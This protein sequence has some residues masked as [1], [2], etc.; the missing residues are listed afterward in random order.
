MKNITIG[1][2]TLS[3]DGRKVVGTEY[4]NVRVEMGYTLGGYGGMDWT[5]RSRGYQLRITPGIFDGGNSQ[6]VLIGG[7]GAGGFVHIED[8]TRFSAKRLKELADSVD[9]AA[10]NAAFVLKDT[11]AMKLAVK[12]AR[13]TQMTEIKQ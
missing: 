2:F 11:V 12:G 7:Y 4:S 9:L 1:F 3:E 8:A 10:V 5:K 6:Y 13:E